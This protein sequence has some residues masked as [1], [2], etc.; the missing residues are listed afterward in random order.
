MFYCKSFAVIPSQSFSF[1][2][3][4]LLG[5]S[6]YIY[7]LPM[8]KEHIKKVLFNLVGCFSVTGHMLARSDTDMTFICCL[9]L[10]GSVYKTFSDLLVKMVVKLTPACCRE[11]EETVGKRH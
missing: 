5:I 2:F 6:P 8:Q 4:S 3:F 11:I 10:S 9:V 7:T 1:R